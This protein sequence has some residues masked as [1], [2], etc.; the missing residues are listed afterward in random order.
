ME[1]PAA[2]LSQRDRRCDQ[3]GDRLKP[4][5]RCLLMEDLMLQIFKLLDSRSLCAMAQ[6]GRAFHELSTSVLWSRVCS[7]QTILQIIPR[8]LVDLL[9]SGKKIS[10]EYRYQVNRLRHYVAS[11]RSVRMVFE[12]PTAE[13]KDSITHNQTYME[14][15][16]CKRL[17]GALSGPDLCESQASLVRI[18]QQR[19]F[20]AHLR[21]VHLQCYAKEHWELGQQVLSD[22]LENLEATLEW[23]MSKEEAQD[24]LLLIAQTCPNLRHLDVRCWQIQTVEALTKLR[25][26]SL[27]MTYAFVQESEIDVLAGMKT[28]QHMSL[29]VETDDPEITAKTAELPRPSDQTSVY[30]SLDHLESLMIRTGDSLYLCIAMLRRLHEHKLRALHLDAECI[31]DR[32]MRTCIM[33]ISERCIGLVSFYW[34]ARTQNSHLKPGEL[35]NWKTLEALGACRDLTSFQFMSSSKE[36]CTTWTWADSDLAE[37]SGVW[38]NLEKLRLIALVNAFDY[39]ADR[40]RPQITWRGLAILAKNCPRLKLAQLEFDASEYGWPVNEDID[41]AESMEM[42]CLA[43]TRLDGADYEAAA[44][45][46]HQL[47]PNTNV[48]W[49]LW[50]GGQVERPDDH[51]ED[52]VNRFP[53][54]HDKSYEQA[55]KAAFAISHYL[56]Y[57]K[58]EEITARS[59][60]LVEPDQYGLSPAPQG[61]QNGGYGRDNT[62]PAMA[63][64]PSN[65]DGNAATETGGGTRTNWVQVLLA[66]SRRTR[67]YILEL[68]I[69]RNSTTILESWL[70][71]P[72]RRAL[73]L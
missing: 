47:W 24:A 67:Q 66:M 72:L 41:P 58:Q 46:I 65:V 31:S 53:D 44:R 5:H 12:E 68:S 13:P 10:H 28:I 48:G 49:G 73:H 30:S 33:E 20:F 23:D 54:L 61:T 37:I 70:I 1:N 19:H 40:Y 3:P 38:P 6:T 27:G 9:V 60:T 55:L 56:Y 35:R 42:L 51:S 16:T 4:V 17:L 21:V 18:P 8:T 14:L 7:I 63:Q 62:R 52:I 57:V 11:T 45:R 43:W 50:Y 64:I 34:H 59:L 36:D 39:E 15:Y 25:L 69:R 2:R 71:R 22:S 32:L 26:R 29:L